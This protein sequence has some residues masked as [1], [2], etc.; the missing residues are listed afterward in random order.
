MFGSWYQAPRKAFRAFFFSSSLVT[1]VGYMLSKWLLPW[2]QA[3]HSKC[4]KYKFWRFWGCCPKMDKMCCQDNPSSWS[5]KLNMFPIGP[6]EGL[7]FAPSPIHFHALVLELHHGNRCYGPWQPPD[8]N[9]KMGNFRA[10]LIK[11][12]PLIATFQRKPRT[13]PSFWYQ[14]HDCISFHCWA[15]MCQR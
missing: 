12:D 3:L 4:L 11:I 1:H 6:L 10:F 7:R 15:M 2:P 13:F 14:S 8:N 5:L 9:S